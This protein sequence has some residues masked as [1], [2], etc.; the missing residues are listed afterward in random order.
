MY[1]TILLPLDG[2]PFSESAVPVALSLSRR[3]GAGIRLVSIVE[4]FSTTLL[5]D[6]EDGAREQTLRYLE[7]VARR[8]EEDA[9]GPVVPE[10]REGYVVEALQTQADAADLVVM[11]THGRG[12]LS[13][14]WLGSVAD[15]FLRHASKPVILVR[16]GEEEERDMT[17]D[18][19]LSRM[20]LP[21]DGSPVSEAILDH[22]V[23]LGSLFGAA[24]HLVRVIPAPKQFSSY[25][26]HM[27]QENRERMQEATEEAAAYL[28]GHGDTLRAR[29]ITVEEEVLSGVQPA[30]GILAEAERSGC[31]FIAV[32]AHG[33]GF[34]SRAVLGSTS[35]K[36][37]RGAHNPLLLYRAEDG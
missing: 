30:H 20:L 19:T 37:V 25:P 36:V 35:D 14:L 27:M 15:A 22:A 28:K 8:I 34:V 29:G 9:G 23:E 17:R 11:A 4:T 1:G 10:V 18:W 31:D 6:W 3:T 7:E 24:Y 16:P 2:S 21:L 5:Y 33:K 32:S 26:P 13:R 12:G